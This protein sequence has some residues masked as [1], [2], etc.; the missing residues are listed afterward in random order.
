[1]TTEHLVVGELG[2]LFP[3]AAGLGTSAPLRLWCAVRSQSST[4]NHH[5][6]IVYNAHG[7]LFDVVDIEPIALRLAHQL[8]ESYADVFLRSSLSSPQNRIANEVLGWTLL[9]WTLKCR[10]R[11]SIAANHRPSRWGKT[12]LGDQIHLLEPPFMVHP[13]SPKRDS[14]NN[15]IAIGQ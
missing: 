9:D 8:L 11:T 1:M 14:A 6:P 13:I 2:F 12:L 3:T 7:S 10:I 4:P 5:I 15:A